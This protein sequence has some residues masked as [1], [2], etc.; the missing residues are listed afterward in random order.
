MQNFIHNV[1]KNQL[2][3]IALAIL[4]LFGGFYSYKKLPIE[5]FP[6]VSPSL[7]QVF[8][9]TEGLSPD[10]VEKYVSYPIETL[11]NGLPKV[12]KIRSVSNFGLSV[13]SIY[14][15]DGTDIYFARQIVNE[16]LQEAR[17]AIPE[18]FGSPELGPIS[19]SMGLILF[20]YLKDETGT[21]S[22]EELRAIQDWL[23]K[24]QLQTVQGV[25]EVL[26][27][28]GFEKQY[29][30][31]VKP[32][33]LL[34]YGISIAE[35]SEQ[36]KANGLNAGAQFIERNGE[37]YIIRSV[38]L[39][40]QISDI[41]N[42]II[43]SDDGTPVYLSDLA[44]VKIGGAIRRGIETH[45]G[46]EEVVAGMVVKL[47]GEN[48][49]TVI[50]RVEEKIKDINK[51]LPE[52]LSV[53]PYYEQKSLIEKCLSTVSNALFQG[54]ALVALIIFVFLRSFNPSIIV[55]LSIP[56]SV[57]FTMICMHYLQISANLMSFGGLA[58]AIGMMV[59]GPIVIVENVCRALQESSGK[60]EKKDVVTKASAELLQS[61]IFSILIIIVVFLPLFSLSGVEG[62]MFKPLAYTVALA[63][64]GSLIYSIFLAPV[65]SNLLLNF[66]QSKQEEDTKQNSFKEAYESLLRKFTQSKI[67]NLSTIVLLL[68]LGLISMNFLG[69]EFTPTLQE[70][71][72]V[73]KLTAPPSTA[74]EQTKKITQL[75]E[76]RVMKIHEVKEIL[77][78][79]GRGEVGA[80][81]DPVNNAEMY[82]VLK[83]KNQWKDIKTQKDLERAVREKLE[84]FPGVLFN[85]T[86]P[87][88]MTV[89]ELLEGVQ[90]DLAIK[91]FGDDLNLLKSNADK[92]S[93]LVKKVKGARDVQVGQISGSPQLVIEP[94]R[95]QIA[96]YGI[97]LAEVQELI[98]TAIGGK[99]VAQLYEGIKRF[100]IYIRFNEAERKDPEAIS[101]LLVTAPN[102][103]R[104]PLVQIANIK[105]IIGPRQI[106]RE[107]NQRFIT[108]QANVRDRDIGSFV[109]EAS[110]LLDKQ[111][112]LP[113][114]YFV[115]WGGQ[116]SLQQEANKRLMIVV[117][118]ALAL[119][120]LLLYMNF[121]S[122]KNSLLILINIPLALIG[123]LLALLINGQNLS[124]PSSIGFIALFGIALENGLV[125]ISYLEQLIQDGLELNKAVIKAALL[126]LRP[127]LMTA[128]TTGLGLIPLLV[129]TGV[130]SEVQRPLAT[131]V[132]GGLIS[133]TVLT[134]LVLPSLY[135]WFHEKMEGN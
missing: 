105:E 133:S 123:G 9:V 67:L 11:M 96:R 91:V 128:L 81:A 27:I 48:S 56:F 122:I 40:N 24:L 106:T 38:G 35:L 3:L 135:K 71:S 29:Q 17:G 113:V 119:V 98:K 80:H 47:Y 1:L 20:Y 90:A 115:T 57:L 58:I 42:V 127:V 77:S 107:D 60:E 13:V 124:V 78:R 129:S 86:Q 46:S 94:N 121:N 130:G 111:I 54:I 26:G 89:D 49:S 32:Q 118:L 21:R 50:A 15:E 55:A 28:G 72:L 12:N 131:V 114:G 62:K 65:L 22:L 70:G 64:L 87:I 103:V 7:V 84:G 39:Y 125:L 36:I 109:E 31:I 51:S 117:P 8:T 52:G 99:T 14:F 4:I 19:S 82:I 41:Q 23:I 37:E 75:I 83:P 16:R 30:V 63:M 43:K 33:K 76:K 116:F 66:K 53:V 74:L 44:E 68:F 108:I 132:I 69:S 85:I 112:K 102:G 97:N 100:D 73:I 95:K 101:R 110:A 18:G 104:V 92:I 134:L 88:E 34:E 126:R 6:D 59:D 45:N 10:D 93:E 120:F 79:V 61:I 2:I 25:T 5:A